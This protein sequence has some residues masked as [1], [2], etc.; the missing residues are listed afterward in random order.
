MT[1]PASPAAALATLLGAAGLAGVVAA[2]APGERVQVFRGARILPVEGAPIERGVLVVAEGRIVAVGAE[3]EVAI[4]EGA[5]VRDL[6]GK[7]LI[8]GLVDPHSHIAEVAGGDRSGTLHPA[9]RAL[10][11]IDVRA[12]SV[13]KARAGG[14]T[15]VNVMPGSGHLISGQTAYL[16]L[17]TG[18]ARVEDWLLCTDPEGQV[19]G[20][21]KMANGTNP[22]RDAGAF[23]RTRGR[24][25]ALVRAQFLRAAEHQEKLA[26]AKGDPARVPARDLGLEALVEVLQGRRIVHFHTHR[27][28]DI[29]SAL[30]L[31]E[32]LGFRPVLH[33]VSDGYLLAP[34]IAAAGAACAINVM[35]A[36]GGKHENAGRRLE[37][38]AVLAAAGVDVAV[39]TDDPVTD[40]RY[41]LRSAALA[42]RGGLAPAR[43]LEAVT[44]AG[45][46][47]LGLEGRVGSLVPGKDADFVV[48]SGDPFSV[49]TQVEETW[50]EGER[51][52]DR[53]GEKRKYQVGG[54][55]VFP[56][57]AGHD[58]ADANEHD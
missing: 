17:R 46:R 16:K 33:H 53:S 9:A 36:P 43:A 20:G 58:H 19:C 7:T 55:G 44:L 27:A 48:L 15:T 28:D 54:E 29:L 11:A 47:M 57:G 22:L 31:G 35:D 39:Q 21:L 52:F 23:P 49:W 51:V 42:V 50:V 40:S 4:P 30:R 32:E 25:A 41:F 26:A 10:D 34:E 2:E 5:R 38:M 6:E 8:P 3:G 14:I 12:A 37:T 18:G 24:S 56:G 13:E 1:A 45:A